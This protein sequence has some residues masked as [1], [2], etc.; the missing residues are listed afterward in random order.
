MKGTVLIPIL[1]GPKEMQAIR[2]ARAA[3]IPNRTAAQSDARPPEEEV[4]TTNDSATT[5]TKPKNQG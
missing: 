5:E 3:R 1:I 4:R 2:N